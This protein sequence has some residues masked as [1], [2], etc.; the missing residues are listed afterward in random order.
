M[1]W[2]P[3]ALENVNHTVDVE[4][5]SMMQ[6][7]LDNGVIAS[8]QQCHY[9]P[10]YWRSYCVI[11]D[12]GRMENFG[13]G[14]DGSCIKVWNKRKA[15]WNAPDEVHMIDPA[16]PDAH[17]GSDVRIISEFLD[18][19]RHGGI[20]TT[21]PLAARYS[22]AAGCVATQSL[23]ANGRTMDVPPVALEITQYFENGQSRKTTEDQLA[24]Y[25][26]NA[27]NINVDARAHSLLP[28]G[29]R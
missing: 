1:V 19:V 27:V 2:P 10:D 13:N 6:M 29:T 26:S 12:E 25:L 24:K 3:S 22:V 5:L 9:T 16:P 14:E 7:E 21:S 4:D 11:G 15:G 23:R 20:T 8:Y 28:N 17:G 18:F